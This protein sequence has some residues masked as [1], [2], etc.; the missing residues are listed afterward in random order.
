MST[1]KATRSAKGGGTI[2][3]RS[4]GR[5]EAR[6]SVG[7]DP[8]TGKQIQRSIYGKTQKEV[9][10]KLARVTTELDEGTYLEPVKDTLAEWLDTWLST[11]V[12]YSVKPYTLASYQGTCERHIKPALGRIKLSNLTAPQIQR[13]YNELLTEKKLSPKTV[14]NVHGV[15]HKALEQAVKLD[16]IRFNPTESCDLPKSSRKEIKP[17]EQEDI[18]NFLQ[19]ICGNKYEAVYRV[20]LFTGMREGE[21]LGLTW[22]CVDFERNTIFV[23]KQLQKTTKV[24]GIYTLAPTKNGRSRVITV[25]PSVMEVLKQQKSQQLQ[26][27]LLAGE[28]WDNPWNLVFT[29]EMGGHLCHFTVYKHFKNIVKEMGLESKRFHDLRHSYAVAAIESGDDIKTVQS[30][31]GHATASFTLD[32]YGHV[33][34]KM[35]QQS[36]DR[37]EAFIQGVSR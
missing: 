11:Y 7:F 33:S 5:W 16:M 14:K 27:Q 30:N 31:L 20:T 32:V 1:A 8:K 17:M 6:Y 37:M 24:G 26:M 12:A 25:A 9:R 22:D 13:F 10:Q 23:N 36:A 19:A 35:K 18:T 29:N 34:Q 15:L 28:M 2:R 4:D 3:K 21:V